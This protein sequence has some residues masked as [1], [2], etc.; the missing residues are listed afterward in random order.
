MNMGSQRPA[1]LCIVATALWLA[2]GVSSVADVSDSPPLLDL[3]AMVG[4]E[5][6]LSKAAAYQC[7]GRMHFAISLLEAA[8]GDP[9][10]SNPPDDPGMRHLRDMR[11]FFAEYAE[12]IEVVE[13][14]NSEH[15]NYKRGMWV[16]YYSKL[17]A[18]F[19]KDMT[20]RHVS[21][22]PFLTAHMDA[23]VTLYQHR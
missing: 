22:D 11:G 20:E 17:Y 14:T 15:A 6:D 9:D 5:G 13:A 10:A 16:S 8:A 4:A 12:R 1:I 3:S 7:A 2:A 21:A 19:P 18:D 23:C